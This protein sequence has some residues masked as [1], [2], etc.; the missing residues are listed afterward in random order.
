M[1]QIKILV[2]WGK[3]LCLCSGGGG[4][5]GGGGRLLLRPGAQI[6]SPL[7]SQQKLFYIAVLFS[8]LSC[9]PEPVWMLSIGH[10]VTGLIITPAIS[11]LSIAYVTS[12]VPFPEFMKSLQPLYQNP[13]VWGSVKFMLAFPF[14]YHSFNGLRHLVRVGLGG[15]LGL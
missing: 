8:F 11:I 7:I 6:P 13:A 12:G 2:L 10:R 15:V 1:G 14:A 3:I 4:G 9:S 5:G